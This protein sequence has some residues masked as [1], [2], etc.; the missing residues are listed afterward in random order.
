MRSLSTVFILAAFWSVPAFA[1]IVNRLKPTVGNALGVPYGFLIG[2]ALGLVALLVV[3]VA[4]HWFT[5]LKP[6]YAPLLGSA[7]LTFFLFL[8]ADQGLLSKF[9]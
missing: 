2:F 9:P 7:V 3:A 8:V 4:S 1:L 5:R 6:S